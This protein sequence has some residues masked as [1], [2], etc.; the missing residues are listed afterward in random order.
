MSKEYQEDAVAFVLYNGDIYLIKDSMPIQL[1]KGYKILYLKKT[2]NT[3]DRIY[4]KYNDNKF[5][6]DKQNEIIYFTK[7]KG[8]VEK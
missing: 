8:D 1:T 4:F 6:Y 2:K 7:H 5:Y 3:K